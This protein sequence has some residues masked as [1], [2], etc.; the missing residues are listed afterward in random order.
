MLESLVSDILVRVVGLYLV[1][2]T[3][4]TV[5]L[6]VWGGDLSLRDLTFRPDALAVLLGTLGLDLPVTCPAGSVGSLAL[7][8]PWKALRSSS[9][10]LTIRDLVVV[11]SPVSDGDQAALT[12]RDARLKAAHLQADDALR[13]TKFSVLATAC[14]AR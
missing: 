2:I 14:L 5:I 1:G 9:V 3:P 13:G 8:V 7:C 10:V 4:E 6:G 12:A 11:A